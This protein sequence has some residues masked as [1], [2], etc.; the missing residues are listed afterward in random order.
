MP[1][2]VECRWPMQK[3]AIIHQHI[4]LS[5]KRYHTGWCL[6]WSTNRKSCM[7]YRIVPS[8]VTLIDLQGHFTYFCLKIINLLLRSL[9]EI[10]WFK[11]FNIN[12]IGLGKRVN[13]KSGKAETTIFWPHYSGKC[14]TVGT[15]SPR[16]NHGRATASRQTEKTVDTRHWRVDWRRIHSAK[17]DVTR[18]STMEK[19][20]IGVVVC[21]RQPSPRKVD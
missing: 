2:G 14:R 13:G 6:L 15:Y 20:D 21:C 12:R 16:R 11:W 5:Q 17:G 18:S 9:V 4:T 10:N 19:K 1:T 3:L 7:I 8:P